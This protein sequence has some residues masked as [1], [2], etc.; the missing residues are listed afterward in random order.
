M[1]AASVREGILGGSS[2]STLPSGRLH[3]TWPWRVTEA[4]VPPAPNP[5]A[6]QQQLQEAQV[7]DTL[8]DTTGTTQNLLPMRVHGL[9]GPSLDAGG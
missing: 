9:G 6:K 7:T 1:G 2:G 5:R 8:R 4:E 3:P